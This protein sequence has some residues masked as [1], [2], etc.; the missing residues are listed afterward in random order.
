MYA[1]VALDV[2]IDRLF[3]YEA[4][5]T[6]IVP[7]ALVR[8][9]FGRRKQ[10]GVVIDTARKTALAMERLRRIDS[11]LPVQPLSAQTLALA[12]F[13]ADYY[14][15]PLGQVIAAILPTMLRR[16]RFGERKPQ[17]EY[18]LT[19]LGSARLASEI[20][21]RAVGMRRLL[22][23][24]EKHDWFVSAN[25]R[26]AYSQASPAL[27]RWLE[28]GYAIRRPA[29][30]S[31]PSIGQPDG[32][33]RL[34]CGAQL[35]LEQ[36]EAVEQV[37]ASFGRYAPWLLQGIT[38]SGKTEVYL[39]LI[40]RA[41]A[42]GG[43][44]LLLTPEINLTPQ[45]EARFRER[46]PN[47]SVV[48]MHSKL[49]EGERMARWERARGGAAEVVL[50]TRLSVFT[51]LPRLA[52]VIVDEEHDASFKQ[53]DGLRYSARDLAVYRASIHGVPVVLG[54]ATPSLESFANACSGRF[55]HLRLTSRAASASPEVHTI[56]TRGLHLEN[57]L[58]AT[59]LEAIEE[60]LER[61]EQSLVYI[62]RRGYAPVLMCRAC[63]WSAQ[64]ERCTSRLTLHL[65]ARR[66]R[67]HY[68]GHEE[69]VT[70]GCPSCG[71]QDLSGMGQGTQ[72]VED[73]LCE[74]FPHAR[75]L[76]IDSDT[77][78]RREAFSR[79]REQIHADQVDILVGTQMLAKGHDFPKLT[80]VGIIGADNGLYSSDFRASE[81]LFQQLMQ[82]A[83]RA[84]RAELPG[85]VLVQTEFPSH[86]L[87]RA[88][89]RHDFDSFAETLLEERRHA[90][91]PPYVFQ[92]LLRAQAH[93]EEVAL[94]FL[95]RAEQQAHGL[96]DGVTVFDPVPAPVARVAG[97]FR[98]QLLVQ[99]DSRPALRQ[100]L[101]RW[102]ALLPVGK[103]LAVRWALDVDPTEL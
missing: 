34:A 64:C 82:V 63:G 60:R 4:G 1:H 69:P 42:S 19:P 47:I 101:G 49:P 96:A 13:C 68:C 26:R 97:M 50:G 76:R 103:T 75:V 84:G 58:S 12:R 53:Q 30:T 18:H 37:S 29:Q 6:P 89:T 83:G 2:P 74:R 15:Y 92:A 41:V 17:W 93:R 10:I 65:K 100:F 33:V 54:S 90:A 62:N 51:P 71:N 28:S 24:L 102:H 80:L 44:T 79:M 43:Q 27:Q 57:G 38:G 36:A 31:S 8:V 9:P 48:S 66:L 11:V 16:C 61:G 39:E 81:R 23:A 40:E 88:L 14:R 55:G 25:A 52:L 5:A 7:G 85:M 78:R 32:T 67:C 95:K 98:S 20:P 70:R 3:D 77:T 35:T 22:A 73:A 21:A 56:D 94:Q 59:M 86:P 45:L 87:Y 46:L 72:R 99:S 91:F